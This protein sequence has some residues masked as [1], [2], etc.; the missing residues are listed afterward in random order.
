VVAIQLWVA[1]RALGAA[2]EAHLDRLDALCLAESEVQGR[3]V[4]AH[5]TLARGD[6]PDV[7][8]TGS[9]DDDRGADRRSPRALLEEI[10]ADPG[11]PGIETVLVDVELFAF[12]A[13]MLGHEQV[14]SSIAVEIRADRGAA[15]ELV[16]DPEQERHIDEPNAIP[17]HQE[18]VLLVAVPG[19]LARAQL[20]GRLGEHARERRVGFGGA[21]VHVVAPE[22]R[23][24]VL[25]ALAALVAVRREEVRVA[26][27]V[28]VE[29]GRAPRPA[30]ARDV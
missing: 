26:V 3:C 15:V 30:R 22:V 28:E 13:Q 14:D 8:A 10:D 12:R 7:C 21:V 23:A 6:A 9:A 24:V 2:R 5:Q 27:V 19:L 18:V 20:L 29:C 1:K 11:V 25:G 17:V 4:L 16:R